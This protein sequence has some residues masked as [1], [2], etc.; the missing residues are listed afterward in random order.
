VGA[1]K[2]NQLAVLDLFWADVPPFVARSF[3][4]AGQIPRPGAITSQPTVASMPTAMNPHSHSIIE[5]GMTQLIKREINP[6]MT[7]SIACRGTIESGFGRREAS[8]P[9][10]TLAGS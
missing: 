8:K 7:R 9:R 10:S 2:V 1:L 4:Q 6:R 5:E 3:R